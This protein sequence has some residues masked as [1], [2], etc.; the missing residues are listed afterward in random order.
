MSINSVN[1]SGNLG[2]D[3]ELKDSASGA[4]VLRFSICV[5]DRIKNGDKWEDKPNWVDVAMFGARAEKLVTF[6]KKGVK[7]AIN[8]KLDERKWEAKDGT[9][10][11]ALTVVAND[12]DILTPKN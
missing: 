9:N 2:Q 7:V 4:K 10:R 3:S 11:R 12:I 5:N 8:G 1:I 6:L